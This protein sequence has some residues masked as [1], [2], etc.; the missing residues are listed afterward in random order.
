MRRYQ[1]LTEKGWGSRHRLSGLMRLAGHHVE[2]GRRYAL[3]ADGDLVGSNLSRS[4]TL[5]LLRKGLRHRKLEV[6]LRVRGPRQIVFA[7]RAVPRKPP[8]D[9]RRAAMVKWC[10]W[11]IAHE[12]MIHYSQARPFPLYK[13]G[14][15]P[16]TLDCSGSTITFA[17]WAG[18]PNPAGGAWDVGSTETIQAHLPTIAKA[19]AQPADVV[20][21]HQ[22]S[23]DV[24]MAV[25]L[26][27]GE[28]PMLES[29]GT[30]AGPR[31]IQFS[32]EDAYHRALGR[33]ASF[34]RIV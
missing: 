34:K 18:L 11:A 32:A 30:E 24:H 6:V 14:A 33:T 12:P 25:V 3:T 2:Q 29:H 26:E 15:L 17:R 9:P 13:P 5:R 10:R 19:E 31:Y 20:I 23:D 7:A 27:A 22:G 21:W 8:L 4:R 1:Q 16:M 28:N